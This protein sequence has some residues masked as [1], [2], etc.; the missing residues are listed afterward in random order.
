MIIAMRRTMILAMLTCL[1]VVA[2]AQRTPTMGWSSWNTFALNI[3]EEL[4]KGQADAMHKNGLQE[5]GYLY[6]NIDDGYW[7]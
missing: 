3:N 5:A 7:D 6:V 1:A 4:I 2:F